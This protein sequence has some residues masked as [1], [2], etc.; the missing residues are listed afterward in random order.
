MRLT[1]PV[2]L[3]CDEQ[4]TVLRDGVVDIDSAGRIGHIGPAAEAPVAPGPVRT[5]PGILMPGLVNAHAHT[6]MTGMRG[7]GGDLPLMR[8]LTEVIWPAGSRMDADDVRAAM[9]VGVVEMLRAGITTSVEMYF[10]NDAVV[11]AVNQIEA[12]REAKV[13]AQ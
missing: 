8:W 2:I 11:D 9:L 6:A 13:T 3:L 10:Y 1:A 7:L 4:C 5:L 12:K